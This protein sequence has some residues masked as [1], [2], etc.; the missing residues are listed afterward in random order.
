VTAP[1]TVPTWRVTALVGRI[2]SRE[3]L[4]HDGVGTATLPTADR[5]AEIEPFAAD[6]VA[7][8]ETM[9]KAPVVPRRLTWLPTEQARAGTIVVE[10]ES[11]D[12]VPSGFRWRDPS[13]V[14][15]ALGADEVAP[16]VRRRMDRMDGETAPLEP[17]WAREGWFARTAAWM[18]QRMA[19][20]N[21]HVTEPP[22]LVYQGPLAAVLRARADDRT[23]F[24]KCAPPAFA[25]EATITHAIWRRTP[26]AVPT[27]IASDPGENW[28][29]MN[30]HRGRL[31]EPEPEAEWI[32]AIRRVAALQRAWIGSAHEVS[33]A[34]GQIRSLERLASGVKDMLEL[35][36]LGDRMAPEVRAA[37]MAAGP[38]LVDACAALIDAGLPDTLVHGDLHP[39]NIVITPSGYLI[40]DWSDAAVGNPFVDLAT[41]LLR[42]KD[43]DRRRRLLEAYLEGWEGVCDRARLDAA[44][45]V[46]LTVG[47]LYQVATYQALMPALDT[48]DR[49]QFLGADVAWAER[50]LDALEHGLDT[51]LT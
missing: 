50:A 20:R 48:P 6:A 28:L 17:P 47:A 3:I 11:L 32:E 23:L 26:D 16:V 21:L 1:R 51:G 33:A 22:R 7:V 15:D 19:D 13:D 12:A 43:R 9:L 14:L 39:E 34:G 18:T 35:D 10:M 30:D 40:V 41:F 27:V 29:L 44:G 31:V 8:V 49:A 38:R 42:T 4:A 5:P 46:A 2:G 25:H 45:D 37:W 24:L 36:G